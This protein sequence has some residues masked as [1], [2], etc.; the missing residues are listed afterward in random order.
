VD[1]SLPSQWSRTYAVGVFPT[2][3]GTPRASD[4]RR[5]WG[6]LE[7]GGPRYGLNCVSP[8]EM[9]ILNCVIPINPIFGQINGALPVIWN[10]CLIL[11]ALGG[12]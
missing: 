9:V 12:P 4:F 10:T 11:G 3:G 6:R 7:G 2:E 1:L 8:V 5:G